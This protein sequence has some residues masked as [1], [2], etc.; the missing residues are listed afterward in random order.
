[1]ALIICP[2]CKKEISSRATT[3]PN[4]GC[5]IT[6]IDVVNETTQYKAIITNRNYR[7]KFNRWLFE[8][9]K[10]KSGLSGNEYKEG[11]TVTLCDATG[12]VLTTTTIST[13]FNLSNIS[14][15]TFGFESLSDDIAENTAYIIKTTNAPSI[16]KINNQV[17]CPKCGSTQIQILRK[18]YSLLTGFMTNKVDRVC[19]N[20]KHK[21]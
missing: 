4:C 13:Y 16:T 7:N 3:C 20:C 10:T 11:D 12:I 14:V 18:N 9:S 2:E 1:M 6:N 5:P 21:F 8:A 19:T 17:V 15:I